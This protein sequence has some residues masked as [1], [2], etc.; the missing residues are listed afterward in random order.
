MKKRRRR[1]S[2]EFKQE[3]LALYENSD[4]A[5]AEIEEE[6]RISPRLHRRCRM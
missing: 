1:Y 3:A 6:L 4:K 5:S 2:A